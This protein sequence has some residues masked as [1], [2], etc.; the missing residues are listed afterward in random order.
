MT[1][2]TDVGADA[3]ATTIEKVLNSEAF[4]RRLRQHG[5]PPFNLADLREAWPLLTPRQQ[6]VLIVMYSELPL[7]YEQAAGQLVRVVLCRGRA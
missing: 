1:A 7:N 6:L 4:Q 2:S 3:A 5:C